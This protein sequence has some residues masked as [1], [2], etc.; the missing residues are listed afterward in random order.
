MRYFLFFVCLILFSA[1]SNKDS[2]PK[3]IIEQK[4]M[5]KVVWDILQADEVAFQNKL[6]DTTILLKAESFRLYDQVF[7]IHR[8]SRDQFYKSY[9]YYQR[10]PH[11]YKALMDSVKSI[12]RKEREKVITPE[13]L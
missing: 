3:G 6:K 9:A 1:C 13:K 12:A 7:A 5:Q 10:H 11:L 2:I 8:T 4:A